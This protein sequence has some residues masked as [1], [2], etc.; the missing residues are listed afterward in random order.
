MVNNTKV[1]TSSNEYCT[2]ES[3][4]SQSVDVCVV[5][6]KP[7]SYAWLYHFYSLVLV[8]QCWRLLC[9]SNRLSVPR[10]TSEEQVWYEIAL[11]KCVYRW[12]SLLKSSFQCLSKRSLW[13]FVLFCFSSYTQNESEG[14]ILKWFGPQKYI[15]RIWFI[16]WIDFFYCYYHSRQMDTHPRAWIRWRFLPFKREFFLPTLAKAFAQRVL[17]CCW[18][19]HS[20]LCSIVESLLYNIEHLEATVAV[21]WYNIK[22]FIELTVMCT[23]LLYRTH[24]HHLHISALNVKFL[25]TFFLNVT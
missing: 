14:K 1:E 8:F 5:E 22:T 10:E 19:F 7:F 11:L 18:S 16:N 12:L 21:I 24:L 2:S 23:A 20:F 6:I 17:S 15:C 25:G 3:S 13:F 4:E 9:F